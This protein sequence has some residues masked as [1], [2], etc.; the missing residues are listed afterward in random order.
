MTDKDKG[1][2]VVIGEPRVTDENKKIL[3][4]EIIAQNYHDEE[5]TLKITIRTESARGKAWS[6]NQ[7]DPSIQCTV[8]GSVSKGGR[9]RPMVDSLTTLHG[10]SRTIRN[11]SD[12]KNSSH[13]DPK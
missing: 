9:P 13:N 11:T 10:W 3:S 6:G 2:D 7:A 8:D 5:E 1:K 4:R 12:P